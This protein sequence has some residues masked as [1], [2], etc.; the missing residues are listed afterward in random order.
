MSQRWREVEIGEFGLSLMLIAALGLMVLSFYAGVR[1]GGGERET[2]R[3]E[4][5][6]VPAI[7]L[8]SH[9]PRPGR[10]RRPGSPR[11]SSGRHRYRRRH[12]WSLAPEGRLRVS[13]AC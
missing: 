12:A 9:T 1:V 8:P 7:E 3:L 4:P 2:V 13:Q 10:W 11:A 5:S 6:S